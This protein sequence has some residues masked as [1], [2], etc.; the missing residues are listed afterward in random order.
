M[1]TWRLAGTASTPCKTPR[2]GGCVARR[3]QRAR[4]T[5]PAFRAPVRCRTADDADIAYSLDELGQCSM[6]GLPTGVVTFL[7]TDIEGS[8]HLWD[9]APAEMD[10]ALRRHDVV[11][12]AAIEQFGG[13]VFKTV[14]DS[15]CAAFTSPF[16]A[17]SAAERAQR[18]V[19]GEPWPEHAP[20]RIRIALH[21]GW[22]EMRD[23]DYVG[24]P[25][26]LTAR[27]EAAAHGGQVVCSQATAE[28]IGRLPTRTCELTYLGPHELAGFSAPV[29]IHQIN[30]P[31]LQV[32]FPHLRAPI[33][34]AVTS[35]LPIERSS[36]LGRHGDVEEV[37]DLV[38][39]CRL[40]TLTG[41]GGVGKTRLAIEVARQLHDDTPDGVWLVELAGTS[42]ET[43]VP[44]LVL[45]QLGIAEHSGR[46]EM[47]VLVETL[48]DQ[49]RLVILDNCEHLLE[50]C[51][52]LCD[53]LLTRCA[54]VRILAT[55]REPLRVEGE[56]VF[57]V[58]PLSLPPAD[59]EDLAELGDSGAVAL[60]VER[61][62]ALH[63]AFR[64]RDE[65]APALA[66]I[67]R[68]LDGMPLALELATARLGSLT[69]VELDQRLT[70]RFKMLTRGSRA[71]L[72]RQQ[73]LQ[74]LIDWSYDLLDDDAQRLFVRLSIFQHGFDL[75]AAEGTCALDDLDIDGIAGLLDSLVDKS[76]V[77]ADVA[78]PSVRYTLLETLREYG[79][80]RL[81]AG[82][83]VDDGS[84]TLAERL[85]A[86]H[87]RHFVDFFLDVARHLTS[88][89]AHE[90]IARGREEQDNLY[91]ASAQLIV[92]QDATAASAT[93]ALRMLAATA[94]YADSFSE[95]RT[96]QRL[97]DDGL[98]RAGDD[99]DGIRGATL[100][101]KARLLMH[102]DEA[103]LTDCFRAAIDAARVEHDVATEV[104]ATA[105]LGA[106][107][108]D[109]ALTDAAVTAARELDE[110]RILAIALNRHG[111][112]CLV[113]EDRE[114]GVRILEESLSLS[115]RIGDVELEA[116]N[117]LVLSAWF[118]DIGDLATARRHLEAISKCFELAAPPLSMTSGHRMN[119]GWLE[120]C[121]GNPAGARA[122][123]H[124]ALRRARLSGTLRI[125]P[126]ALL[127]LARCAARESALDDAVVLLGGA[128]AALDKLSRHWDFV[129]ATFRAEDEAWLRER[130]GERFDELHATLGTRSIPELLTHALEV[131]A[132]HGG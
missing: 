2:R 61:A 25:V 91:A 95:F 111:A 106:R 84:A 67:C 41:S 32:E 78:R 130:V 110:P 99:G 81:S 21:T 19:V 63:P 112:A 75:R 5:A 88:H 85:A 118:L 123:F 105:F 93:L 92:G 127:G 49:R 10:V 33:A 50:A 7:F 54:D 117:R 73:T 35:N 38:A 79:K 16:D 89:H 44:S 47:D 42:E 39:T 66:S 114:A 8:T 6:S 125:V 90:W 86:A 120:V 52:R 46:N 15:F 18:D 13:Q 45:A 115:E 64:L 40:V 77:V 76:L 108:G 11:V 109:A 60:F 28:L 24:T 82:E 71:A 83:A 96:M 36:F 70:Q 69:L 20:I 132:R 30:F 121:E 23:Q 1:A 4:R 65:D 131:S 104:C 51:A 43:S 98:D 62:T 59:V 17:I 37:I 26:N 126:E 22:C 94:S 74:A 97:I 87:A 72:P 107:L 100:Y 55:S 80:V 57:R 14:G 34:L 56:Q 124:D 12:R 48:R 29:G 31:G 68:R 53:A 3:E 27:I 113:S 58:P 122:T 9:S 101:C 103:G 128:D 119:V 129:E 102:R 116:L